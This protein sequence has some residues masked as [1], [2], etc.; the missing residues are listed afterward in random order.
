MESSNFTFVNTTGTSSLSGPAAKRMRAH[1][2]RFNF[3]KRR[4]RITGTKV[5]E[6]GSKAKRRR[7][8]I[9]P[10]NSTPEAV[11]PHLPVQLNPPANTAAFHKLQELVF[12]EGRHLPDSPSEAAWFNLIASEPAL[13]EASLAVAVR[14]WSPE[15]AWQVKA[16]HH[17]YIAVTLIKERITSISTRTDGILGAVATMAFGASLAHDDLARK[18]HIDGL[19]QIIRDRMSRDPHLLPSWFVDLIVVDSI[20]SIMD[21]PRVWHRSVIDAL[22][23]YHGQRIQKLADICESVAQLRKVIDAQHTHPL[24]AIAIA[25][26]I[27]EPVARLHYEAR[28]LRTTDNPYI[29]SAARAIELVLYLLWPTQ[30]RAHLT[31]L[32]GGLKDAIA[33]FPIKGCPY[34]DLSSFLV[35]IGAVAADKGSAARAW[36]VNRISKAVRWMQ[37]RGWHEPLELLEKRLGPDGNADLVGRFL[38]LLRELNDVDATTDSRNSI[39]AP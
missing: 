19:A 27:E 35:M 9:I 31:Y 30:S 17:S 14:Q 16:E 20:N 33:R 24:N 37:T 26:E 7:R 10:V 4:E 29:D 15:H 12:L 22:G 39:W 5:T 34:M 13:V 21:F 6:T 36:F 38:A 32:A 1:I 8:Q 23:E 11:L 3:A 2:T 28:G 18:I 25:R